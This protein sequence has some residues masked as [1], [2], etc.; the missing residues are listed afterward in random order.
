MSILQK[1]NLGVAPSGAGGDDQRTANMRFNANVDAL[2]ARLPLEYTYLSDNSDLQPGHVGTRFC[3][4]MDKAGK[5]VRFPNAS[6]VPQN[7]CFHLFNLGPAVTIAVQPGDGASVSILNNGDW[8]KY[9]SDGGAY[10][11]V[12]E[13]GR[14]SWNETV[15]GDL[16]V[17]GSAKIGGKLEMAG[18]MRTAGADFLRSVQG[19]RGVIFR[20]DGTQVYLL[21]TNEGDPDGG[22]NDYRP[23]VLDL[24]SG[25]VRIDYTG[26]GCYIGSRP[27]WKG[28]L[29]PWDSGNFNPANYASLYSDQTFKGANFFEKSVVSTFA[30]PDYGSV[31]AANRL[32]GYLFNDWSK[33]AA[34]VR[35][36][37][38]NNGA[39]Y[40]LL[41]A[42]KS[43]QRDLF[44]M[45]IHAGGSAS[46]TAVASF[47]FTGTVNAH[48][49]YDGGNAAFVGSLSQG[50]DYR[51][52]KSVKAIDTAAA[53]EGV[54]RLRF[55]D[56]LKTTNVGE[57]AE[58]RIAGVIAHEAQAVFSNVVSGEKD[59][60]EED[61]RMKLQT[62]DYG[63]LGV[64]VGAA[65]QHMANL[66]ESLTA[67]VV[68][69]RAEV[70]MLR[71]A[72]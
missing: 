27:T 8:A 26:A 48:M 46:A 14:V 10:W 71:G 3:L 63:G 66:I 65:V 69:L 64:Y 4:V 36:E 2:A 17:G 13:R 38:D 45:S 42:Q 44:A 9:V 31:F 6:S 12:V 56:Y 25:G 37:C 40:Q 58:R 32:T 33:S 72:R 11:H 52:K 39:A 23:F 15:G 43:G 59:A 60:V 57:D 53:Y 21:Q 47:T 55:V 35:V 50:S 1:A 28:G 70:A 34:A 19:S 5:V 67:D 49:F 62:V 51:I 20:N 18:G 22:W 61:G 16:A 54:R 41:H 30:P 29:T 68:K 24:A 7:A